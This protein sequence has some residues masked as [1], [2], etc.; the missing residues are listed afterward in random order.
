MVAPD[1][2]VGGVDRAVEIIVAGMLLTRSNCAAT[3]LAVSVLLKN[4]SS[5]MRPLNGLNSCELSG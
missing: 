1:R 2:V 3:S 4:I 5:S